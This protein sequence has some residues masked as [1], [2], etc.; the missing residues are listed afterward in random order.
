[1]ANYTPTTNF[2]AKDS[3]SS[4]NPAKVIKGTEFDA[5]FS[6]IQTAVGTKADLTSP[7]LVTPLLGTPTSGTLTNCTGL[8]VST[9]IAGLGTGVATFLAT[10]SSANLAAAVTGETGTGALVF[11][12]S[13]TLVTPALGTPTAGVMTNVTGLPLTTGVTGILPMANGGTGSDAPGVF[14]S[15]AYGSLQDAFDAATAGSTLIIQPGSYTITTG[16]TCA[17]ELHVKANGAVF[18]VDANVTGFQF[19]I[20]PE[21]K[22]LTAN[23]V[24]GDTAIAVT[25]LAAALTDGQPFKIVCDAVDPA[26]RDSGSGTTQYR[27][28]EWSHAAGGTTTSIT[29]RSP[30]RF[31]RGIDTTSV[32]GQEG[33]VDAYTTAFNAKVV[34][35]D[36]ATMSWEG[37]EIKYQEGNDASW[38]AKAFNVIGYVR[39]VIRNLSVTRGYN[40]AINPYGCY[41]AVVE[42][43]HCE[44]LNNNTTLSQYGYG[45]ADASYMTKVSGCSFANVRH[46]YTTS[47]VGMTAGSTSKVSLLGVGRVQGAI[48]SDCNGLGNNNSPFDTHHCAEDVTFQNCK[49]DGGDNYGFTI[50]GRNISVNN[51]ESLNTLYGIYVHTEYASGNPDDD[52]FVANKPE[53]CTT[54]TVRGFKA[55][56]S[57]LPFDTSNCRL[58]RIVGADVHSTNH[59]LIRNNGGYVEVDGRIDFTVSTMDGSRAITT[60]T[61]VGTFDVD[62]INSNMT[63]PDWTAKIL[64]LAGADVRVDAVDATDGAN[65]LDLFNLENST[66]YVENRGYIEAALSG[67]FAAL[68]VGT[69]ANYSGSPASLLRWSV[70]GAADNSITLGLTGTT[71]RAEAIDGTKLFD[72]TRGA[73]M[74]LLETKTASA[75]AT[76]DFTGIDSTFDEYVVEVLNA[77]PST[78][79]AALIIRTSTDGGSSYDA[80]ASDYNRTT[81]YVGASTLTVAKAAASAVIL[82]GNVGGAANEYGVSGAVHVVR[83]SESTYCN[84]WGVG[85]YTD[86]SGDSVPFHSV[87]YRAA[88]A[89]VDAIRFLF[90]SGNITSGIFKLYGIRKS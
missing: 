16:I 28:G 47:A 19:Y 1:M 36:G 39:P 81:T 82:T 87:G 18:N 75:S 30:L 13:P 63:T 76:I 56:V 42:N 31:S 65:D 72:A 60:A 59:Q 35:L 53:G 49:A 29:L 23:Y 67:D 2:T 11:A 52:L 9:G 8:P 64:F 50:R 43:C 84:V 41:R 89:N 12:T 17:K 6:A 4:G 34:V 22:A 80:G 24:P 25:A 55:R 77:I 38:T 45:V 57:S 46:G 5:E 61:G 14:Y 78:D 51:C 26:N 70:D 86:D 90:G 44:N 27:V 20:E 69:A 85:Q 71:L 15:D 40:A 10:P 88:A 32:A 33:T 3:L 7:T 62:D 74:V 79:T 48:I 21:V 58:L 66:C 54:A 73:G 68:L 37:G 83:P